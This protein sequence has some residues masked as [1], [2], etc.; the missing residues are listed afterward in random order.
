MTGLRASTHA[1]LLMIVAGKWSAPLP[2]GVAGRAPR[3]RRRASPPSPRSPPRQA[4]PRPQ[5]RPSGGVEPKDWVP[6]D[7]ESDEAVPCTFLWSDTRFITDVSVPANDAGQQSSTR[8]NAL[9]VITTWGSG[10]R[11]GPASQ[12]CQMNC[13]VRTQRR[14]ARPGQ[15]RCRPNIFTVLG[16]T[17]SSLARAT[18]RPMMRRVQRLMSDHPSGCRGRYE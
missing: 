1:S 15:W 16:S 5:G 12:T 18:R 9:R 3:G 14:V 8:E 4:P 6:G 13:K 10:P 7:S 17:R 2:T 11:T